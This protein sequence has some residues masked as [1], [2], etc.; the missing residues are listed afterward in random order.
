MHSLCLY[1]RLRKQSRR[2]GRKNVSDRGVVTTQP[3]L[4]AAVVA[5]SKLGLLNI[6]P[7]IIREGLSRPLSSPRDW[8]QLVNQMEGKGK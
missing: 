4:R 1:P 6:S 7:P 5:C 2:G 3:F 8:R